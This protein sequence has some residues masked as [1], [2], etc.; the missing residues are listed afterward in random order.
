MTVFGS[1]TTT[2]LA[3]LP[4]L[5]DTISDQHFNESRVLVHVLLLRLV[6]SQEYLSQELLSRSCPGPARVL[7]APSVT[8][9]GNGAAGFLLRVVSVSPPMAQRTPKRPPR[10]PG[11]GRIGVAEPNAHR[12]PRLAL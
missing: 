12:T 9:S 6:L 11:S 2:C 8:S 3:V 5:C 7:R 4:K 1:A 10:A